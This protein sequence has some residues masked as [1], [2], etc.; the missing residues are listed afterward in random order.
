[1]QNTEKRLEKAISNALKLI[2]GLLLSQLTTIGQ[3]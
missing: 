3:F 2:M 1:M